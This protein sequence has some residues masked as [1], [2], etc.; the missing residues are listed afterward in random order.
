MSSTL[1]TTTA[2]LCYQPSYGH[3]QPNEAKTLADI[4]E[5]MHKIQ[6]RTYADGG[7]AIRC[8]P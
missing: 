3:P 8:V 5:Q 6:E 1:A 2:P 7:K 4:D